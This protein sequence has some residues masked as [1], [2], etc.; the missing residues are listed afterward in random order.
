[1]NSSVESG[2]C[3]FEIIGDSPLLLATDNACR[4][5][6]GLDI[7]RFDPRLILIGLL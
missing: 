4:L 3:T 1:M 5:I 7:I 6:T 2:Q